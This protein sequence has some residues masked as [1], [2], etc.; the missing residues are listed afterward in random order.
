MAV[1][2]SKDSPA[3]LLNAA[4][5]QLEFEKGARPSLGPEQT[6]LWFDS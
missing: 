4:Y 1:P 3:T 5:E 2:L 6:L